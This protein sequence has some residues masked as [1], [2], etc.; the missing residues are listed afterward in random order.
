MEFTLVTSNEY[1]LKEFRRF[2]LEELTIE[3][4]RD[5]KEVE[6]DE[7]TVIMYKALEA[8]EGRVV[9]DTS[10]TVEGASIGVNIR[11]LLDNLAEY[12]GRK[13]VWQVYLGL[14]TGQTIEIYCAKIHGYLTSESPDTAG[15]GFDSFFVPNGTHL[16]LRE[17]ELSGRK[18]DF[19]A[20]K[21]AVHKLLNGDTEKVVSIKDIEEWTGMY[22]NEG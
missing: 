21:D 2:G 19:S 5:L 4:G 16:T 6:S 1:K 13:A 10:L 15:F 11:W 22:Q 20:R 7:Q 14:H 18:D 3:K 17:L 9:E 12:T 8:G